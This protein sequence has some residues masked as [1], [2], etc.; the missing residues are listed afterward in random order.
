VISF[1]EDDGIRVSS[2]AVFECDD[3]TI[4]RAG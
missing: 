2:K 1:V 4:I 3:T